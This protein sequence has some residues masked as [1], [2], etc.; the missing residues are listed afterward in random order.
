MSL[1]D[2]VTSLA[3]AVTRKPSSLAYPREPQR[4]PA[5]ETRLAAVTAELS[6]LISG[7][8]AAALAA[9]EEMEKEQTPGPAVQ[10]F[11]EL[12]RRIAE[13]QANIGDISAALTAA[14]AA[15]ALTLQATK[16]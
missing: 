15:D 9:V 1:A 6:R 16:A 3:Q 12:K 7:F 10:A 2:T 14:T 5:I 4:A 8:N 13:Q 11:E